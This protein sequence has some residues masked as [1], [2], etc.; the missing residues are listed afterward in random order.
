MKLKDIL[1]EVSS[2]STNWKGGAKNR[3][4]S[5]RLD[6]KEPTRDFV[7][8]ANIILMDLVKDFDKT[9]GNDP[10]WNK[11]KSLK[12]HPNMWFG[13]K[14]EGD[15]LLLQSKLTSSK[16][17]DFISNENQK[18]YS[19]LINFIKALSFGNALYL[20]LVRKNNNPQNQD[21]LRD[22]VTKRDFKM[23]IGFLEDLLALDLES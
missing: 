17:P 15:I 3:G 16:A 13:T 7:E 9:L 5:S 20:T 2:V 10:K 6:E 18:T 11:I 22:Q 14:N 4:Y 21:K 8:E 23:S 19:I 1:R 12:S